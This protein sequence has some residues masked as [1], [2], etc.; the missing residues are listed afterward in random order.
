MYLCGL[1]ED[2]DDVSVKKGD[3]KD[4]ISEYVCPCPAHCFS[5][6][7]FVPGRINETSI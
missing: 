1:N 3:S 5:Y 6:R 4:H 2:D 7:R